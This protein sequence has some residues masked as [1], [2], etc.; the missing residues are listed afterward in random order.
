M[1]CNWKLF[2]EWIEFIFSNGNSIKILHLIR[3][4][5]FFI[6]L[7]HD[8]EQQLADTK[9]TYQYSATYEGF[10]KMIQA[11]E[12]AD[13]LRQMRYH[14]ISEILQASTINNLKKQQ[15]LNTEKDTAPKRATKGELLK[16][17]NLPV[18][19]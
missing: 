2:I 12:S 1:F 11:S 15:G 3:Y 4:N 13:D 14:I 16:A 6:L 17:R 5:F 7:L 8:R 18:Y 19:R 10:M 9:R